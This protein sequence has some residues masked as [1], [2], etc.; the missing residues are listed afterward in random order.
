MEINKHTHMY[1]YIYTHVYLY[2][3]KCIHARTYVRIFRVDLEG[4][5]KDMVKQM[6]AGTR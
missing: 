2:M 3:Y 1:I 6:E 4:G 5:R